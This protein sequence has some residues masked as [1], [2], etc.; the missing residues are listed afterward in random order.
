MRR[1][2]IFVLLALLGSAPGHGQTSSIQSGPVNL[3][4]PLEQKVS[5]F[6]L[7]DA[8]FREGIAE[9]SSNPIEGLHLGFEEVLRG[10]INDNPRTQNPHFSL[11]LKNKTVR[12]VLDILC[13]SD[14]RYVW[15][16]DGVTINVY[17]KAAPAPNPSY[18]LNYKLER[19]TVTDI[20]NPD[21]GLTP[22]SKLLPN[23]QIGY[24][25]VGSDPEYA[26]PWTVTLEHLTVRQFINRLAE[27]LGPR[28]VWIWQGSKN[29]RM[30]TFQEGGFQSAS[31]VE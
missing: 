16:S 28:S 23:E 11:H 26:K 12:E 27:H 31:T 10:N 18:L 7:R 29:E 30:F 13:D 4:P 20:P 14:S 8:I 1:L 25:G 6:E 17:P 2:L 19:I 21:Q 15:S 9:L 5:H 24:A 3:K 22:L